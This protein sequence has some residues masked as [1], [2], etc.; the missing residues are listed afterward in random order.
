[1]SPRILLVEDDPINVK[2]LRT[3]LVK[4]GGYQV[5][6]SEDV[7][8]I[9]TLARNGT[10]AAILMDVSLSHSNHEGRSVDG[11]FITRLLKSDAA[12]RRV[13]V[14]LTTAHAMVGD[15][16]AYLAQTGA[17]GY[18][19]KPIIDPSALLDAVHALVGA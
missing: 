10:L 14:L 12:A 3:V 17:D 15:R 19:A 7:A 16:E 8:E 5:L 1:M 4:R 2:F 13:P 6:V 9:L 11:L 18:L